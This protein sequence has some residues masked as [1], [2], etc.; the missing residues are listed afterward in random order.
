MNPEE[1]GMSIERLARI[2]PVLEKYI[3]DDKIAGMT[4][5]IARRGQVVYEECVGVMDRER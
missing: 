3:A 2:R 5:V 1:V 4:A